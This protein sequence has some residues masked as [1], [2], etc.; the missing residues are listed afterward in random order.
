MSHL[1][2]QISVTLL[3]ALLLNCSVIL[4]KQKKKEGAP[5]GTPVLW[6]EPVDITTRDL[7]LGAGG[8]MCRARR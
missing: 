5:E 8:E 7:Y 1:R 2:K 4:A 3:M 6:Q